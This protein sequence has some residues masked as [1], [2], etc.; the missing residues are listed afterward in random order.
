MRRP[1]AALVIVAGL[2]ISPS[3]AAFA[4]DGRLLVGAHY[5]SPAR[6]SASLGVLVTLEGSS[7]SDTVPLDNARGP[8][9]AVSIGADA[10][11][12]E[13]GYGALASGGSPLLG[14]G[15]DG[16]LTL[17]RTWQ[18]ARDATPNSTYVGLEAGLMLSLVR[19]SIGVSQRVAGPAGPKGTL[20]TWSAGLQLALGGRN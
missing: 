15:L 17:Q 11:R 10:G 3:T 8:L 5:A 9:I 2:A 12:L 4:A 6:L 1:V 7:A 13:L 19:V 16:R 14:F 18:S 20:L